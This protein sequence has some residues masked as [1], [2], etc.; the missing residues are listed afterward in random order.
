MRVL[1]AD[2]RELL[3]RISPDATIARAFVNFPDPWWKK[4]HAK[5]RVL[6]EELLDELARLLRPRGELFVQ[7]DV[8]ERALALREQLDEH[9]SFLREGELADNPYGARSNREQSAI[10]NGLPIYRLLAKRRLKRIFHKETG[11]SGS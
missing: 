9:P 7:T 3:P 11:S 6:S 8:E 4:R 5:R 10:D 2:V 1:A